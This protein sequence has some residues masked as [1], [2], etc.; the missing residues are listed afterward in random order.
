MPIFWNDE[1]QYTP[2]LVEE[3]LLNGPSHHLDQAELYADVER[4]FDWFRLEYPTMAEL[5]QASVNGYEFAEIA[6]WKR[7]AVTAIEDQLRT[8]YTI[9]AAWLND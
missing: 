1:F 4:A 5:V 2:Q 7:Q 3:V 9:M 8:A 6:T